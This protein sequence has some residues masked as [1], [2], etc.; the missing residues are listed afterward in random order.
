MIKWLSFIFTFIITNYYFLSSYYIKN[1]ISLLTNSNLEENLNK[2]I[3]R[4]IL[5][6]I[7][8][9]LIDIK[10]NILKSFKTKNILII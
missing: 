10:F 1:I 4:C 2:K 8:I 6:F 7:D 3:L 5:N 9:L